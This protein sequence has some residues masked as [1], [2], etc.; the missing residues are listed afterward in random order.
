VEFILEKKMALL[1]V[2][3]LGIMATTVYILLRKRVDFDF[4]EGIGDRLGLLERD[5]FY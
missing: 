5:S 2:A 3:V 1:S 4:T